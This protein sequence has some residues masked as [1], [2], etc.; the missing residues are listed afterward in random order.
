MVYKLRIALT[1]MV[2]GL[3]SGV[4]IWGV[5]E[6]TEPIIAENRARAELQVYEDI[7]PN[8][9]RVEMIERDDHDILDLEV[10]VF[11][12]DRE[13]GRVFRGVAQGYGGPLTALIGIN[14]DG[15]IAKVVPG[16]N[17]ETANIFGNVVRNLLP[18]YEGQSA[19]NLSL[20]TIS[21]ATVS[22]RA[23]NSVLQ[24]AAIQVAGDPRQ[25]AYAELFEGAEGYE[26]L[27]NNDDSVN[28]S[29]RILDANDEALGRAYDLE[30]DLG[31]LIV[32]LD[33]DMRL[34]GFE[35]L[36]SDNDALASR[37]E[38]LSGLV[39]EHLAEVSIDG[40]DSVAEALAAWVAEFAGRTHIKGISEL[41]YYVLDNGS[42]T[43][44]GHVQ[45]FNRSAQN[46]FS[47]TI[48]SDGIVVV[49]L[50]VLR[51]SEGWF[52][53]E[54]T[55]EDFVGLLNLDDVDPEDTYADATATGRSIVNFLK[56][57][58]EF[59]LETEEASS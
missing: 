1:L 7:F 24:A 13:L 3:I 16:P 43:I 41:D 8:L 21:G 50:L 40:D 59:Y 2:I 48:D 30:T 17:T 44:V 12:G 45:G 55:F 11:D 25:E 37:L 15:T 52:N 57:A 38:D 5:N 6:W 53:Y 28:V 58:L 35:A 19:S 36:D 33:Y 42:M 47:V 4:T 54:G 46:S 29:Y 34:V 39:G 27:T 31:T 56:A 18:S 32:G 10:I 23:I 49:E 51:D 20:D 26:E 14:R 22:S 9:T